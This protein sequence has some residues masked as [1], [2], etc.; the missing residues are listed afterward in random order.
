MK[1]GRKKLNNKRKQTPSKKEVKTL[2]EPHPEGQMVFF[3]CWR[4]SYGLSAKKPGDLEPSAR[5][6]VFLAS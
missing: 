6:W 4:I 3:C 2:G 1:L 5:L